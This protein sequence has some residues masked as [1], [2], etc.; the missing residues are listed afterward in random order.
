MDM[1]LEEGALDVFTTP[2]MMKKN[3][4]ATML[5]CLC[6]MEVSDHMI[7]RIL[8]ETTTIGVR[9][10]NYDR[11]TLE[12]TFENIETEWGNIRMKISEGHGIKKQKP[13]YED[14]RRIAKEQGISFQ[15]VLE[16]I[17]KERKE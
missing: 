14:V 3:R 11:K 6:S 5:T 8:E 1:L 7:Q 4:P 10:V 12:S 13:E 9:Y 16:S 17:S 15:K 2:I